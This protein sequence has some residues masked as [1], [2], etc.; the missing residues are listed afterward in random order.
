M[1]ESAILSFSPTE[2]PGNISLPRISPRTPVA[3]I[4]VDPR[5]V[6]KGSGRLHETKPE[7]YHY[8]ESSP[9]M[10]IDKSFPTVIVEQHNQQL[11]KHILWE[12]GPLLGKGGFGSVY[13][14]LSIATGE[15]FAVK[16]VELPQTPLTPGPRR[17][18]PLTL[19]DYHKLCP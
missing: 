7:R 14:G 12:R 15:L 13:Q 9:L 5:P 3:V 18:V 1:E 4:P 2:Q 16:Q 8:S 10:E 19:V 11:R 17:C 6:H